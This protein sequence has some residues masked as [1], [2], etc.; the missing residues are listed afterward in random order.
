MAYGNQPGSEIANAPSCKARLT[1][2]RPPRPLVFGHN[3]AESWKMVS[4]ILSPIADRPSDYQ[5][6]MLE[7]SLVDETMQLYEGFTFPPPGAQRTTEELIQA[8]D[9]FA[10]GDSDETFERYT[11]NSRTQ[12]EGESVDNFYALLR[13]LVNTCN[14]CDSSTSSMIKDQLGIEH[15]ETR[16]ELLKLRKLS[17]DS[18]VD[19]CNVPRD[20][21]RP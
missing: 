13:V 10:I 16:Q 5:V 11:F 14:F 6:T 21:V 4:G 17:L 9:E 8:F 7:N 15:S 20:R 3:K 19:I 12:E 1:A 2:A 18:Y